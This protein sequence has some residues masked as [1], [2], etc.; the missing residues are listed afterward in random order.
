MDSGTLVS[1]GHAIHFM[2]SRKRVFF[3][4]FWSCRALVN[5]DGIKRTRHFPG[6]KSLLLLE[7]VRCLFR[8]V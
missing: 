1:L 2:N 3:F 7:I 6:L 8:V 4:F 5:Q